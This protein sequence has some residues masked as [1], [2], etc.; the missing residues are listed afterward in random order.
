MF[1]ISNHFFRMINHHSPPREPILPAQAQG[2]RA[3]AP[4]PADAGRADAAA[5]AVPGRQVARRLLLRPLAA[6]VAGDGLA[7]LAANAR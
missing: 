7:R 2:P 4:A 5:A 6:P 3:P 1:L